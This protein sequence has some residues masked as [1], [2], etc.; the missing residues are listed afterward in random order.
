M[1]HHFGEVVGY[2]LRAGVLGTLALGGETG[3]IQFLSAGPHLNPL[4]HT[5][6]NAVAATITRLGGNGE[7]R[8]SDISWQENSGSGSGDGPPQPTPQGQGWTGGPPQPQPPQPQPPQPQPP[9]RQPPPPYGQPPYGGQPQ[10]GQ[11]QYGQPQYPPP[12]WSPY[13]PAPS[14]STNG[15]AIA[16]LVLGIVWIW[17]IT[18]VLAVIF[19]LIARRQIAERNEQGGGM[20]VAGIVLG[21]LGIVGTIAMIALVIAFADDDPYSDYSS[22]DMIRAAVTTVWYKVSAGVAA[23]GSAPPWA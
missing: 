21:V 23:I 11:P 10:Y 19:G 14:R 20:A 18:S 6:R 12:G 16:S 3:A 7:G 22:Y 5:D 1:S 9:Q 17:G 15:L 4:T 2:R 8:R 13:G